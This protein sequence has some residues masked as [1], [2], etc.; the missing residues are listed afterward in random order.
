MRGLILSIYILIGLVIGELIL[1]D[2][3]AMAS[4][5]YRSTFAIMVFFIFAWPIGMIKVAFKTH[6][7]LKEDEH[8]KRHD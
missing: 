2:R 4:C 5:D 8:A 7:D 1:Y 3:E 6:K